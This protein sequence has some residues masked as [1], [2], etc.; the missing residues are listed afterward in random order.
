MEEDLGEPIAN[1]E[2][3]R[4]GLRS[5]CDVVEGDGDGGLPMRAGRRTHPFPPFLPPQHGH[6][7]GVDPD[8]M[9]FQEMLPSQYADL[10]VYF[11]HVRSKSATT[12]VWG[13]CGKRSTGR[14]SL[15]VK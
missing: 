4:A 3:A 13:V 11:P 14:A 10:T 1:G 7:G 15:R 6:V 8:I 12:S 5:V 2:T 9:A